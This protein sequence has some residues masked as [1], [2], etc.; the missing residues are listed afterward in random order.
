M[1]P[2]AADGVAMGASA[3]AYWTFLAILVCEA[4]SLTGIA[5]APHVL[6]WPEAGCL[7]PLLGSA[8][9]GSAAI[10]AHAGLPK[11][12]HI[13]AVAFSALGAVLLFLAGLDASELFFR[14][15]VVVGAAEVVLG[16]IT[17]AK[18]ADEVQRPRLKEALSMAI[19]PPMWTLLS[20]FMFQA[21]AALLP[22]TMDRYLWKLDRV[23]FD[24]TSAALGRLIRRSALLETALWVSE[25][26]TPA[27]LSLV[28]GILA[29][30][31]P[32]EAAKYLRALLL[33]ALSGIGLCYL[34]PAAGPAS[35]GLFPD[36]PEV[37]DSLN[38]RLAAAQPA[39][40]AATLSLPFALALVAASYAGRVSR[41]A[42]WPL[43]VFGLVAGLGGVA[44]GSTYVVG[45]VL[46][47]GLAFI[48]LAAMR[49]VKP[50]A[51]AATPTLDR[52]TAAVTVLFFLSGFAGLLYEVLFSKS[53]AVTFG[54]TAVASTTVLATYMGGMALGA[55]VG[56]SL[57][58]RR[59]DP[60]R[61]YALCEMGIGLW[62]ASSPW[63]VKATQTIYVRL[64]SG[65][66]PSAPS[67]VVLQVALGSLVLLPPT[68]LMGM[69]MP[70]LAKHFE[71]REGRLG[72][73]VGLLYASNTL[74]AALGALLTGYVILPT[75]GIFRT[76]L[77]A[78]GA[79]LTVA[80]IALRLQGLLPSGPLPMAP[81]QKSGPRQRTLGIVAV[82]ILGVGGVVSL[83]LENVYI[84]LLAVVAGSSAFAFS[85]MLFSFL[86]GLGAGA[87]I[88]RRWLVG[89]TPAPLLVAWAELA[90][91]G[92]VLAGVFVW[93]A[94]PSYFGGFE[95]YPLT[96]TFGQR[97]FVR[98][99]VCF[100]AMVPPA[101]CIGA[102]FTLAMECVGQAH[103]DD[104]VR[105]M[106]RAAAINTAGNIVGA[107]VGGFV[108][109]PYL[110]SLRALKLLGATAMVLSILP[111]ITL[112]R[113]RFFHWAALAIVALLLLQPSSFDFTALASG[114]NVYFSRQAYGSVIDHAE[115]MDGGLTT[116]A[117]SE[118]PSGRVLTLLTNGKFQGD[119]SP[120]VG[121]Q[122][123]FA[124]APMLH[125]AKRGA[126]LNI[127]LG[128]GTTAR[129]LH[130]A[131]FRTLDIVDL[132]PDI[133]HLTDKY[134][135]DVN[136]GVLREPNVN[137]FVTDGR[138]FITIQDR[139]YDVISIELT[140]IWFAGAAS[141][142][143]R[144]FYQLVRE[145]LTDDGV[146]SQW[147]QL[148][149]LYPEHLV[150]IIATL[151]AEFPKV[152]LY[153]IHS[154]GV[155]VA[156]RHDCEP[157]PEAIA[158]LDQE[159]RMRP[160]I[161]HFGPSAYAI[162]QMM[163]LDPS[164][165]D[166]FLAASPTPPE[167]LISTDD[168]LYLEYSTP[169]ANVRPYRPSLDENLAMLRGFMTKGRQ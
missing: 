162:S 90:L 92:A 20:L 166:R 104:R 101:F 66:D 51:T 118:T 7:D 46:A 79:N 65:T 147:I 163:L 18:Y 110:G 123:G 146:L 125:T 55:Y 61:L 2:P 43:R 69:T 38:T 155:L 121:A 42:A 22:V 30:R 36:R 103:P 25:A 13:L 126:A 161:S 59:S 77:L 138:N 12:V 60:V 168:N 97:E 98:G 71:G 102:I 49:K 165:I 4:I 137:V 108:L 150:S 128:T 34:L 68:I 151:R 56:G 10:L 86:V 78:V 16:A 133:I 54:S 74:G 63:L 140:S 48:G 142:Y 111:A 80:L 6:L 144:E 95:D 158:K 143:N 73:A 127:G 75:L 29:K 24:G 5:D 96:R 26:A 132:S 107:M 106:G 35:F 164:G 67:L 159:P 117:E 27:V 19:L 76:T 154:Q 113:S 153:F 9:L 37:I 52:V 64:A 136:Q 40:R 62:C 17:I 145:R 70:L 31:Q 141:L 94:L 85:L 83:A 39:W 129:A 120:E 116:V 15:L 119:N 114:T 45:L 112:G 130:A 89:P 50:G 134:F 115:S 84:H 41:H 28:L 21:S 160:I 23:I 32:E 93:N 99:L 44:S 100:L 149:R 152:Y 58:S 135:H 47:A 157:K 169:R 109:L 131:G 8:F 87:S 91:A 124:L 105:A 33:L 122:F 82:I 11:R 139:R 167:E 88:A 72:R 1:S 14:A 3:I 148:H 57:G 156:C 81:P 53:L